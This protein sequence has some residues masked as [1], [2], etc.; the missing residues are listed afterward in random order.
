MSIARENG[1]AIAYHRDRI[2]LHGSTAMIYQ[3]AEKIVRRFAFSARPYAIVSKGH[4]R[5]TLAAK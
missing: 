4:G 5:I 3:E 2:I 1:C